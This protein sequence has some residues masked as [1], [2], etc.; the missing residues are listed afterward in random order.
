MKNDYATRVD[1]Q[2]SQN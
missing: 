1:K 2:E